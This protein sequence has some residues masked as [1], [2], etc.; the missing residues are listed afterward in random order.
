MKLISINKAEYLGKLSIKIF[1]DDETTNIINIGDF[2]NKNPHPQYNKYLDEKK[3]KNFKLENG[4]IVW[5]KNWDLI[6]PLENLYSGK[7]D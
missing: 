5:G 3:A 7:I 1:F 2:I 4:N 6:F